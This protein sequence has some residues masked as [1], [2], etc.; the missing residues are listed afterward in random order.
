MMPVIVALKASVILLLGSALFVLLRGA[1]PSQRHLIAAFT[2]AVALLVAVPFPGGVVV[3]S[4][5]VTFVTEAEFA[6]GGDSN[7]FAWV[8]F[9]WLIGAALVLFRF[10]AGI[11]YLTWMSR[12]AR[13]E[14]YGGVLVRVTD[15]SAPLV[16][17]WTHPLVLVPMSFPSWPERRR[18]MA[19]CHERAHVTRGDLWTGLLAVAAQ[20]LYWYNP[21]VWWLSSRLREQQ[22]L[23]CDERVL[24][25]GVDSSEYASMLAEFAKPSFAPAILGCAMASG[26]SLLRRRIENIISERR[27][28]G[29]RRWNPA[30]HL[31]LIVLLAAGTGAAIAS[32][33][34]VY[35]IGGDVTAPHIVH[36]VEP[37]Y[38]AT[39]RRSRTQ[40]TVV[41]SVIIGTNGRTHDISVV[42]SLSR[43]LDEQAQKAVS[44]WRFEPA[45]KNGK[46]VAVTAHIEV[47]FRLL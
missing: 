44:K 12:R 41:L 24:D 26:P 17:G 34:E 31:A 4:R 3:E 19:L 23:A 6:A 45:K 18:Q 40:G 16:W 42:K 13:P 27:R 36:K 10:V 32:D 11:V 20:C 30:L 9:V 33:E 47:N 5:A 8:R 46:P 7:I 2:L 29:R 22:E 39:D 21:L 1:R 43:G 14:N 35:K 25:S 37:N 15:I 28:P 38:T